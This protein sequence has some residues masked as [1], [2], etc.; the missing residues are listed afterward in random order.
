MTSETVIKRKAKNMKCSFCGNAIPVG[1]GIMFVKN[2][3]KIQ[4]FCSSKCER[5][6]QMGREGKRKKWTKFFEKEV[7]QRTGKADKK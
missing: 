5:N 7:R 6:T 1:T 2:D 3:G 4:Y